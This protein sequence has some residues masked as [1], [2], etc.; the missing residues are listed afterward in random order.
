MR[1]INV[2]LNPSHAIEL[3]LE[4][5]ADGSFQAKVSEH[6]RSLK[7]VLRFSCVNLILPIFVSW[8]YS[9]VID[10]DSPLHG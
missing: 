1:A 3:R 7:D 4:A 6:A 2:Q 5:V 9:N 8:F 10:P